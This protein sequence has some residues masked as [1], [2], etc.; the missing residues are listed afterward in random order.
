MGKGEGQRNS[1]S[2]RCGWFKKKK[3]YKIF[4]VLRVHPPLPQD[5]RTHKQN[6]NR[7]LFII[8]YFE[9]NAEEYSSSKDFQDL[10]LQY[11]HK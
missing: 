4:Q 1:Y 8:K 7:I 5:T 10:G 6:E 2:G 3:K 9:R 11:S